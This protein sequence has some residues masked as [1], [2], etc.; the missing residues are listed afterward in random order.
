MKTARVLLVDDNPDHLERLAGLLSAHYEVSIS[1]SAA[2]ALRELD[3][4][5][6]H[7]LVLGT[8][9]TSDHRA[10]VTMIDRVLGLPTPGQARPTA[11]PEHPTAPV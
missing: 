4:V 2:E 9:P 10:L 7:V 1:G 6:P 8:R 3:L 11:P 5:T